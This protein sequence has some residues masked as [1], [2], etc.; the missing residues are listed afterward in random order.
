MSSDVRIRRWFF[1][2]AVFLAIVGAV[3]VHAAAPA[4][5]KEAFQNWGQGKDDLSFVQRTRF[6]NDDGSLKE[7]RVE[8]YDPSLPDAKRWTL[9][10]VNGK[11][12]SADQIERIQDKRNKKPRKKAN[13]PL[14]EYFDLEGA[15]VIENGKDSVRYDVAVKPEALRL[16]AVEKLNVGIS[17]RKDSKTIERVTAGLTE[18]M[19]IAL[20]LAKVTDVDLDLRFDDEDHPKET[21]K[22]SDASGEA[23]GTARVLLSKFGNRAEYSWGEFKRVTRYQA[24]AKSG[25]NADGEPSETA[26]MATAAGE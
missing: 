14:E 25:S 11:K 18:P 3:E 4:L 5:L 15:R 16:I 21:A 10:E 9:L 12:P 19:R 17:V 2:V 6:L 20:G 7:E 26:V 13:K 8:R 23:D 22:K 24:G 1:R